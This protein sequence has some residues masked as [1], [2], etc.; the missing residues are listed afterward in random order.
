MLYYN[1][2]SF[3]T[4][5]IIFFCI[6]VI[7]I[8][9]LLILLQLKLSHILLCFAFVG[10]KPSCLSKHTRTYEFSSLPSLTHPGDQNNSNYQE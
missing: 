2:Y 4:T 10:Q 1:Y 3:K 5:K 8:K 7:N 6:I 9:L